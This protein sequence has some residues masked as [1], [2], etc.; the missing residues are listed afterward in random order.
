[1][2]DNCIFCKIINKD[3]RAEIVMEEPDY[4]VIKDIEPRAPT[5]LLI[6][7][8][9]HIESMVQLQEEDKR[10]YGELFFGIKKVSELMGISEKGFRTIINCGKEAG[11][12]VPHLHIHILGGQKLASFA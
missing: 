8:K 11:Q 10:L 9:K 2:M 3:I 12:E 6:I 1:M 7:S 5:H 4:L